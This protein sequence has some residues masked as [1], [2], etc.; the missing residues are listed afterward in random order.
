[1]S[2]TKAKT[3]RDLARMIDSGKLREEEIPWCPRFKALNA[4]GIGRWSA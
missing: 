4:L 2:C 1:M 3:L